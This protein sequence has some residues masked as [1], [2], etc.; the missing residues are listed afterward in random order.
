MTNLHMQKL[1][2]RHKIIADLVGEKKVI[3]LNL[4]GFDLEKSSIFN[5]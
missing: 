2:Y 3:D 5:K 4:L 1:S